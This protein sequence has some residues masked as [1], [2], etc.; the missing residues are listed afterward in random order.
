[1]KKLAIILSVLLASVASMSAEIRSYTI[2]FGAASSSTQTLDNSDFLD[3]VAT[4]RG[5]IADVTSVVN[6]FPEIGSVKLSSSKNNGKFNIHLTESASIIPE[7]Y[8]VVAAR[9]DNT[10][11]EQASITIN[12]ETAFIPETTTETY[13]IDIPT[14]QPQK[15]TNLIVDANKRLYLKSITVYYDSANGFVEPEKEV[16]ATPQFTPWGGV[17]S[18]GSLVEISCSTADAEIHYTI[19]G[20]TPTATSLRYS[21]PIAITSDMTIRAIA[22]KEGM[23]ASDIAEASFTVTDD[24]ADRVAH[25]NFNAP[26]TLNPAIAEPARS[27]W[28]ELDNRSF[29]NSDVALTFRASATGNTHVRLYHSY[30]AGCDLRIYDG[31]QIEVKV[32]NPSLRLMKIEFEASESGNVGL[33]FEADC[34]EFDLWDYQW[35]APEDETTDSVALTSFRQSRVKTMTVYL[36]QNTGITDFEYDRDEEAVYYNISGTRV[37]AAVPSP[38]FYIRV[39]PSRT[40]KVIVK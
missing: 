8:E 37:G 1:M 29:T 3:A 23:T 17:V 22:I 34:G 4:G 36:A 25:F 39:T 27:E 5:Y 30:D 2:S 20:T 28:V 19:D 11:D 13:R 32:M 7:Y 9:Y 16:V 21:S 6:V 12:G 10:R 33:E 40:T 38:G 26:T 31:E 14:I 15:I 24:E 18:V 35:R